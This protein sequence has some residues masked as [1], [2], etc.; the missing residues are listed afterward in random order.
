M[1]KKIFKNYI[2]NDL[3]SIILYYMPNL[4]NFNITDNNALNQD[5][6]MLYENLNILCNSDFKSRDQNYD[7][8]NIY[9]PWPF[10]AQ[11]SIN[12]KRPY[13]I[14]HNGDLVTNDI[15]ALKED[16]TTYT[17][18]YTDTEEGP[19]PLWSLIC[20]NYKDILLL[21]NLPCGS[22]KLGNMYEQESRQLLTLLV[23]S[24]HDSTM[25]YYMECKHTSDNSYI[26]D[27]NNCIRLSGTKDT[28]SGLFIHNKM[29][30]IKTVSLIVGGQLMSTI[31]LNLNTDRVSDYIKF[32]DEP[33]PMVAMPYSEIL[34]KIDLFDNNF[35]QETDIAII[36]QILD[37]VPRRQC[38]T[39][40][41]NLKLNGNDTDYL[42]ISQGT[43]RLI[44]R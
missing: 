12:T 31:E 22:Y 36:Y 40:E 32:T 43:G 6:K 37:L 16:G 44:P 27:I 4:E 15:T 5:F 18:Q 26:I 1:I 13:N 20:K 29:T 19:C 33:V 14:Y 41:F 42:S 21:Y 2:N 7:R 30:Q 35:I 28:F 10:V 9:V 34:I 11:Q 38:C 23:M 24:K 39:K 3:L 17:I 25:R 8:K